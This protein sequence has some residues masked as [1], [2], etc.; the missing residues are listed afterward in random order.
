M[1]Y[2]E[3]EQQNPMNQGTYLGRMSNNLVLLKIVNIYGVIIM[4][5]I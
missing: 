4:K 5:H 3:K 2:N 1:K